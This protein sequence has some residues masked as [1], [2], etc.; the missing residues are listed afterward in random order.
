[1]MSERYPELTANQDL[2][3]TNKVVF[4]M[5]SD[6]GIMYNQTNTLDF[7]IQMLIADVAM[8]KPQFFI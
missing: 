6:K 7:G 3:L 4:S 8:I 1:M 2:S 5:V